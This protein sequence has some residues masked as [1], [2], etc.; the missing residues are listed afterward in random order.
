MRSPRTP[1][2]IYSRGTTRFS[3]SGSRAFCSGFGVEGSGFR[4]S[5]FK[6]YGL[7]MYAFSR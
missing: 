5:G 3:V 4:G 1:Y 7:G 2:S 6:L